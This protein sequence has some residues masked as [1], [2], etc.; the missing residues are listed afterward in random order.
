MSESSKDAEMQQ[1]EQRLGELQ[2]L[3]QVIGRINRSL[4]VDDVL[5]ASQDGILRVLEGRFGCFLLIDLPARQ[6]ELAHAETL[7][8][9][10][11]ESLRLLVRDF[12]FPP[13][14]VEPENPVS[15][16]AA[17]GERV[18]EVL[19]AYTSE[20]AALIPLTS[21]QRPV[22]ILVVGVGTPR[23]LMPL[24]IDL[25]MFIGE[26]VGMAIENARLHASQER[27]IATLDR[28]NL[29][30]RTL[31]AIGNILSHPLEIV[32]ALYQVCEQ[33]TPITGMESAAILLAD[34]NQERLVLTAY[35]SVEA[36]LLSEAY[37][38]G[39]DDPMARAIAVEGQ[40]F[41]AD[42]VMMDQVPSFAGPRR[43]GYHAGIGV[44][45][46]LRGKPIGAM[47][48]G[49]KTLM[50]YEKADVDLMVNIGERI[51]MA[52]ENHNL[53][54]DLRRRVSEL[55]G[56]AQLSA[57]G[58][59]S[60]DPQAISQIAVEWTKK[61]LESDLCSIRLLDDGRLRLGAVL[62]QSEGLPPLEHLNRGDVSESILSA[63][64]P[65]IVTDV[66]QDSR[67]E[68]NLR[69]YMVANRVHTV[70]AA[71]L[72]TPAGRI[73]FI[74]V[75]HSH[76]H[77]WQQ[78]EI[79]LLQTIANQTAN[80]I[81][82][83]QL[84][85]TV[86]G[87]QRKVQAIFDSG[88]SGLF[89]TDADGRIVMFNRA[90]ER[91]TGWTAFEIHGK[92]WADVFVDATDPQPVKPLINE[93]L[94][95]KQTIYVA[96]GRKL[97]T[98]DGR[99]IPVAKAV[100]PLMDENGIVTGAVGAFWDLTREKAAE[101][102]RENFL[103]MVAHQMRN[104]LTVLGSALELLDGARLTKK[105]RQEMYELVKSQAER[106]KKFSQQF[107]DLEKALHSGRPVECKSVS[108]TDLVHK[109]VGE[110]A[111]L[112]RHHDFSVECPQPAP[113]VYADPD[114][115][116]N[117]L[118]NLLDN[119]VT[120]SDAGTHILISISAQ[121]SDNTVDIAVQDEGIGIPFAEQGRIFDAFYRATSPEGRHTYGHGF[122][123]YV[124]RQMARQMG[125]DIQF[126]SREHE[127]STFHFILR[128]PE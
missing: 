101:Q 41:A 111:A 16:I 9:I 98:R 104:P 84:F 103:E 112:H 43:A 126:T 82:N 128:R 116:D 105:R 48:V 39:L 88:I 12:Q 24:S 87:E 17:L 115:V 5:Q 106:L 15:L 73:G 125:G 108:V 97:Q 26:Q 110:F 52:L 58:T 122:G 42:D 3:I 8:P 124:A 74:T 118:R 90:A 4:Q 78:H 114:R 70:L 121:E 83:A 117:V 49:S 10:L 119:A 1:L 93:A 85:Q 51:G 7:P 22:G 120:Y 57:A 30:L 14:D 65:V 71:P 59:S 13:P 89:A 40:V 61:L 94:L 33:I 37:Q 72:P 100:A 64:A 127:G 20:S 55:D 86:L 92:K 68:P 62:G 123:L 50:R 6:L 60:L 79:D 102:T 44:P 75:S 34:E 113:L 23:V 80:A 31:N 95:R 63:R 45:I 91:I 67:I 18:R 36:E 81:H 21:R 107:L 76:P 77:A 99:V 69:D 35:H 19:Q 27:S 46:K 32:R 109:L 47:F 54:A 29:E 66:A 56:L 11:G 28:R 25:L 53:Y 38:V 96:D 2:A